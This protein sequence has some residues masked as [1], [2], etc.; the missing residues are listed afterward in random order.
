MRSCHLFCLF[1]SLDLYTF[2]GRGGC[3]KEYSLYACD[4]DEK[5][6][7]PLIRRHS[8]NT[9][10]RCHILLFKTHVLIQKLSQSLKGWKC[11][12]DDDVDCWRHGAVCRNLMYLKAWHDSKGWFCNTIHNVIDN[13]N[14]Y[15]GIVEYLKQKKIVLMKEITIIFW[16]ESEKL[17]GE[18]RKL[19]G[20]FFGC[21]IIF[22]CVF[23]KI[24]MRCVRLISLD[25]DLW[26][27]LFWLMVDLSSFVI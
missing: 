23:V 19:W 12:I 4:N 25:L 27:L 17:S 9:S 1:F 6:G 10:W 13:T 15:C 2:R 3:E 11:Y 8:R 26:S 7:Q 21:K 18:L 14:S 24:L 16:D 5:D 20:S 22:C